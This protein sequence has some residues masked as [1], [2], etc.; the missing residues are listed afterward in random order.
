MFLKY[1]CFVSFCML[2]LSPLNAQKNDKDGDGVKDRLD[3]CPELI[4]PKSNFGCPEINDSTQ[5]I[6]IYFKIDKRFNYPVVKQVRPG[7]PADNAGIQKGDYII[8]IDS[9]PT[10]NLSG[11]KISALIHRDPD[12]DL[13]LKIKRKK[14]YLDIVI[15]RR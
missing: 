7:F 4:G 3:A 11:E 14:I 1:L 10:A 13:V 15:V 6:G 8:E 5:K 9:L 2:M 12:N